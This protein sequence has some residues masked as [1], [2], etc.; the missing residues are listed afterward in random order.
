MALVST[1]AC[2]AFPLLNQAH[3]QMQTFDLPSLK[4][5]KGGAIVSERTQQELAALPQKSILTK[6]PWHGEPT[7]FTGPT[8]DDLLGDDVDP[9]DDLYLTAVNDYLATGT[10]SFFRDS[11]AVFAIKENDAFLSIDN[12]GP[13]F[14]VFPFSEHPEMNNQMHYSRC[15]WQLVEIEA[16]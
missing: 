11:G 1:A 12:K 15:V 6:T 7:R 2:T 8:I 10:V 5:R 9:S 3:A 13:V 14:I 16:A 4:V